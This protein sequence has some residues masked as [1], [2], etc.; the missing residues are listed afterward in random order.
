MV[1]LSVWTPAA[2]TVS[3]RRPDLNFLDVTEFRDHEG[4]G[5]ECAIYKTR[6][7]KGE[8]KQA[9]PFDHSGCGPS[10]L[11]SGKRMWS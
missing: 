4:S 8:G 9:S 5:K 1:W 7:Q 10:A 2:G 6:R 3:Q 11:E